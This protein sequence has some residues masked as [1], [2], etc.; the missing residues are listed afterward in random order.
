MR[1]TISFATLT[2]LAV[3]ALM[4]GMFLTIPSHALPEYSYRTSESCATC[5]VNPGGGGPRTMRGLLWAVRGKPDSVP[6][7]PGI[8]LAPGVTDGAE[9]YQIACASCHGING[10][11]MFG[12]PLVN[13]GLK[14]AKIRSNIL[15]GRIQSGM[16]SFEGKF[17]DE[18]LKALI[19]FVVALE[20]GQVTPIP[21]AIPLP[22]SPQLR[23]EEQPIP[24]MPGGN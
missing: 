3:L 13:R 15:R 1:S 12:T 9:L 5:H 18:Q 4:L 19:E 16:P 22:T 6:D 20:N 23:S 17:T 2:I 8:L 21:E 24:A 14:E 7:L 10:E 11:G